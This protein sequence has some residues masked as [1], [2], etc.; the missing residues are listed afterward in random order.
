LPWQ[1]TTT[2]ATQPSAQPLFTPVPTSVVSSQP[3][4]GRMAIGG[5]SDLPP[6][7]S[8]YAQPTVGATDASPGVA[9]AALEQNG[10]AEAPPRPAVSSAPKP[11]S[12]YK[13]S[14]RNDGPGT[15][16]YNLLLSLGG[17]Y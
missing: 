1:G 13:R 2:A 3:L 9:T 15:P 4:P 16:R 8:V 7:D 14:N 12:S 10:A 5:P 11:S 6:V 17:V